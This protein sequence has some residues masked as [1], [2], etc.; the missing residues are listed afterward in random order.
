[1]EKYNGCIEKIRKNIVCHLSEFGFG[2]YCDYSICNRIHGNYPHGADNSSECLENLKSGNR[3]LIN[4]LIPNLE[5]CISSLLEVLKRKNI[6]LI[7]YIIGEP[8]IPENIIQSLLPHTIHM[9]LYNN[10]YDNPIIHNMPIGIRDGEEVFP[11][12]QNYSSRSLFDEGDISRDKKYLCLL[13][14]TNTHVERELCQVELGD[15][16]F[17]LNLMNNDYPEQPSYHCRKVP[18]WINYQNTH[19]SWYT[20]SP[21]GLGEATH[22]FFEAIYLDSIP[23]VKRTNTSFDKL[24]DVFPCMV[25]EDWNQV[26]EE[27]L[28]EKREHYVGLLREFKCKYPNI[29]VNLEGIEELM[30]KT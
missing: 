4:V 30:L 26:T 24:Y 5:E 19:E 12:H 22:R 18:V 9:F 6:K 13:C 15:K 1:M 8:I 10:I 14:F 21:S 2:L 29:Y 25:V 11:E 23:I 17:V 3:I 20:L 7:F 27:L 28:L 16:S